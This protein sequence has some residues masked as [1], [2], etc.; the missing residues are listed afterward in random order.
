LPAIPESLRKQATNASGKVRERASGVT[1]KLRQ[2][3]PKRAK[4]SAASGAGGAKDAVRLAI[5]YAKQETIDPIKGL[6]RFIAFGVAGGLL[7]G[8]GLVLLMLALLRALQTETGAFEKNL[9]WL[10]YLFT[11]AGCVVALAG[12]GVAFTRTTRTN[13]GSK[14]GN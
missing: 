5:A 2:V 6:G 11:A 8:F 9:S 1:Q 13:R 3:D 12:I 7:V 14:G 10:P 4:S